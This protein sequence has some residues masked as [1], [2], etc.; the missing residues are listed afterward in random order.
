MP[1]FQGAEK[2]VMLVTAK[3]AS[4]VS[5]GTHYNGFTCKDCGKLFAVFDDPS[6][7]KAPAKL[8]GS[9]HIRVACSHCAAEHVY[10]TSEVQNFKA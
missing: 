2:R 10:E 6:G 4:D 7:G 9:G 5:P 1:E 8:S 3:P